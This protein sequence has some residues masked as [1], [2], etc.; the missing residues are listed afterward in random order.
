AATCW[1]RSRNR[2]STERKIS[3]SG[4]SAKVSAICSTRGRT[5]FRSCSRRRWRRWSRDSS[6]WGVGE[7]PFLGGVNTA[8]LLGLRKRAVAR[9]HPSDQGSDEHVVFHHFPEPLP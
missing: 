5:C 1:P 8:A 9:F 2:T 6:A 3:R 7:G 4:A